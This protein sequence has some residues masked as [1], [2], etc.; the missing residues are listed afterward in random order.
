MAGKQNVS[1]VAAIHDALRHVDSGAR[2]RW[3]YRSHQ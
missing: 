3:W 1:G 2:R